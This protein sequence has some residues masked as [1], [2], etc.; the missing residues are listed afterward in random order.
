MREEKDSLG[1]FS[2]RSPVFLISV[3]TDARID[4]RTNLE[5]TRAQFPFIPSVGQVRGDCVCRLLY[6]RTNRS[7]NRNCNP[8]FKNA[9]HLKGKR[10]DFSSCLFEH[11]DFNPI[12]GEQCIK[13]MQVV[14]H[15]YS[16]RY[17]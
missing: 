17:I 5:Y 11:P 8:A 4:L 16:F 15:E 9:K 10:S 3:F 6:T 12:A 1:D 14:L 13:R 7:T 2:K